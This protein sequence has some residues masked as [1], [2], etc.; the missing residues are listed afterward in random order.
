LKRLIGQ[1][2]QKTK[3][4]KQEKQNISALYSI[5]NIGFGMNRG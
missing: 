5:A 1:E 3:A 4:S 2:G